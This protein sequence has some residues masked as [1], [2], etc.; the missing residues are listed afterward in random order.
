MVKDYSW[1]LTE[2]AYGKIPSQSN[3]KVII[4][5]EPQETDEVSLKDHGL[6]NPFTGDGDM[7]A[8]PHGHGDI[9]PPDQSQ[10][11]GGGDSKNEGF[12]TLVQTLDGVLPLS[13]VTEDNDPHSEI[14]SNNSFAKPDGGYPS[15]YVPENFQGLFLPIPGAPGI[16]TCGYI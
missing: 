4:V 13:M 3:L 2:A 10:D 5:N 7:V 9:L 11:D 1:L 6:G 12:C 14:L 8:C 16:L 15:P